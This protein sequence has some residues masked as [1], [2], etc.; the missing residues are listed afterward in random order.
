MKDIIKLNFDEFIENI[1]AIKDIYT[2]LLLPFFN[3]KMITLYK[4]K[5]YSFDITEWKKDKLWEVLN[6]DLT[7]EEF[8]QIV[9]HLK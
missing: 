5:V 1:E 7:V 3:R 9:K 4:R 8:Y 2:S 6:N